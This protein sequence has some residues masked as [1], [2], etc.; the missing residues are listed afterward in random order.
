MTDLLEK[1]RAHVI[2]N[3]GKGLAHVLCAQTF[4]NTR[5]V[6]KVCRLFEL[7]SSHLFQVHSLGGARFRDQLIVTPFSDCRYLY[8]SAGYVQLR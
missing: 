2:F 1:Q 4:H 8:F 6:Q 7:R 3:F 5:S